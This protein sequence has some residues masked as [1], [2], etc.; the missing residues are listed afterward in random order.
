MVNKSGNNA[1]K[2]LSVIIVMIAVLAL[3]LPAQ[4]AERNLRPSFP[5]TRT[6]VIEINPD[7]SHHNHSNLDGPAPLS[8]LELAASSCSGGFA[9]EYP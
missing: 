8:A 6:P 5:P 7:A 3:A 9:G 2:L 1:G 4:A